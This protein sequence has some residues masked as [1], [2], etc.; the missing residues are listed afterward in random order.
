MYGFLKPDLSRNDATTLQFGFRQRYN[1]YSFTIDCPCLLASYISLFF[2]NECHEGSNHFLRGWRVVHGRWG[3]QGIESACRNAPV[4]T[5]VMR[6]TVASQPRNLQYVAKSK[7]GLQEK[8]D[9]P[10]TGLPCTVLVM[11]ITVGSQ[12]RFISSIRNENP[13]Q[14][15]S[16]KAWRIVHNLIQCRPIMTAIFIRNAIKNCNLSMFPN[17]G[18]ILKLQSIATPIIAPYPCPECI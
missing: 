8:R 17:L 3:V 14:V 6:I 9:E 5:L 13:R 10:C 4:A 7:S 11:H 15:Y 16:R 18:L 2:A 12:S 1:T